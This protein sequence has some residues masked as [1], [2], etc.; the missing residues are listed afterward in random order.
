MKVV[1]CVRRLVSGELNPFDACAYETALR[2]QNAKVTLLSMGPDSV[3]DFLHGLTR[4]GA[5]KAILLSDPA[6]AGADTLATSY[7]LSLALKKLEPDL[8][9][10]GRQTIDGDTAQV[11]P[12]T[13]TMLGVNLIT[14]V[15]E[16]EQNGDKLYFKTRDNE[17]GEISVPSLLT[18]ERI[19]TL[20][21]PSIRSKTGEIEVWNAETL[22]ADKSRCGLKGS[23]TQV[24][25]TFKNEQDR[26]KCTFVKPDEFNTVLKKALN[27]KRIMP[28]AE[29]GTK[30]LKNVWTITDSPL[31]MAKTVSDDITVVPLD[32]A[33]NL[34]EKIKAENPQ[35]ILWGSDNASKKTAPQVA[36]LLG[37]GLCADCTLLETDGK[38]LFM[39]RPA[40]SGDII[41]KIKC[42]TMPQM[43]TV[44][45]LQKSESRIVVGLGFGVANFIEKACDFA[46][47][48]GAATVASRKMVDRDFLPYEKQVGL[49]GK[50]V[51]PDVYISLGISGAVHHIAGIKSSGII[52]AVNS[53]PEDEIFKYADYGIVCNAEEIFD[54]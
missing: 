54:I 50:S 7:T 37:T 45:T 5:K 2:L 30:K 13:A 26:R 33:E 53:D 8:I 46:G 17:D 12:E 36:A 44:R 27:T 4:L 9:F 3:K 38:Q 23:P 52:I 21:L 25:A 48:L 49:T 10:C 47:K 19:N 34:V 42:T 32:T 1:V 43:A 31:S 39:Y 15:M 29:S 35:V 40:F 14:N 22:S 20:R 6:F 24:L 16:I 28:V 18:L 11:G 41:A 51:N